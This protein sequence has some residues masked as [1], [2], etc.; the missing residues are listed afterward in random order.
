[1]ASPPGPGRLRPRRRPPPRLAWTRHGSGPPLLLVMGLQLP[2]AAWGETAV[3]LAERFSVI[4]VDNP[5]A[6]ASPVDPGRLTTGRLADGLAA[7][8]DQ[9]GVAEASVYGVSLGGMVAQELALRH[10]RR[11]RALVL[12]CTW[13]GGRSAVLPSRAVL[14]RLVGASSGDGDPLLV[15]P[16]YAAARR[17]AGERPEPLLTDGAAAPRAALR[18]FLAAATHDANGRLARLDLPALILHGSADRVVPVANARLLAASIPG[19]ELVVYQG[20]GHAYPLEVGERALADVVGFLERRG[21]LPRRC[22]A[23]IAAGA[24]G[25][26]AQLRT[27]T[28]RARAIVRDSA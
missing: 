1:M 26:R 16:A 23:V 8:L 9:A 14:R 18:Q 24:A 25:R 22:P 12:G 6:G 3:R 20:V 13:P 19:A 28:S 2:A 11:V 10:P 21:A 5:G 27:L 4:A 17:A 15:S 7:V